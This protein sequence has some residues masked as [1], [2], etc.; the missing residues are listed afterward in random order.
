MKLIVLYFIYLIIYAILK[1]HI[2]NAK[3]LKRLYYIHMVLGIIF[4]VL[5]LIHMIVLFE[6]SDISLI[7]TGLI[8][9]VCYLVILISGFLTKKNVLR[10]R[11]I[12]LTIH[13][14][15]TLILILLITIHI[16]FAI[17]K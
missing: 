13:I 8:S 4:F 10:K 15:A 17:I 2:K 3:I 12:H 7:L 11:K 14:I 1:R 5:S 16:I 9:L 6:R